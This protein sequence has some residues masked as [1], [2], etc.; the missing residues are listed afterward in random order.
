VTVASKAGFGKRDLTPDLGRRIAGYSLCSP[1]AQGV[2]GRLEARALVLELAGEHLALIGVD[3]LAGSR[4]VAVKVAERLGWPLDRVLVAG[5][6]V[7]AGPSGV[8]AS[9]Y[10]DLTSKNTGFD[11]FAAGRAVDAAHN[12]VLD[13]LAAAKPARLGFG[14]A[15]VA[16]AVWNRSSRAT[17]WNRVPGEPEFGHDPD[18]WP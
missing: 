7:H 1:N 6:H 8:L 15:R 12:A 16:G 4:W 17:L 10:D 9:G 18:G 5:T 13:A 11:T 3:L 2:M 14:S